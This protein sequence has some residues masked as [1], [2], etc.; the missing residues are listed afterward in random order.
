MENT[1]SDFEVHEF[2]GEGTHFV[3]EAES[4]FARLAGREDEVAL[5]LFLSVHDDLIIGAHDLVVDIERSSCLNLD[6]QSY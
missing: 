4:V 1:Y 3:I 5:S 2:L 6:I